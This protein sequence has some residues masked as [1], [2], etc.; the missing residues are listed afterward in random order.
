MKA[1]FSTQA[2][3]RFRTFPKT[4]VVALSGA[5]LLAACG[6]TPYTTPDGQVGFPDPSRA[7]LRKG[8]FVNVA[9]LRQMRVGLSKNQV[10]A[11]I[12]E[13][14]FNEGV[15]GVHVWNYIF[16]FTMP[17]GSVVQC[18]YQV[19]Y[20]EHSLVKAMYW[21]DPRCSRFLA[22]PA[23][24]PAPIVET[25][26]PVQHLN[27]SGDVNF[28][29]DLAVLKPAARATLNTLIARSRNVTYR[30]V[31]V[32]GYTD[33]RASEQHNQALSERRAASVVSYLR[34]HGLQS[35]RYEVHGYGES[36]PIASNATALG[37]AQNRRVE[38]TLE[39][40]VSASEQE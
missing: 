28:D 16:D 1:D 39:R 33:S 31:V 3:A 6:T 32:S 13:P 27:L 17:N 18:Q 24:P 2:L 36:R 5:A 25:L 8:T 7:W 10:Y 19:Q 30:L 11:L 14:H 15:I 12:Q 23:P 26:P 35:E 40:G 34:Q 21:R 22:P 38:I 4:L 29:T 20:D 9:N 37:R